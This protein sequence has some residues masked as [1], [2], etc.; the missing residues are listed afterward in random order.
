[1]ANSD[2]AAF[3]AAVEGRSQRLTTPCG[4]GDMVWHRWGSAPTVLVLLHGGF[5]SWTHW[6]R[7]VDALSARY[8]VIAADLPGLGDSASAPEPYDGGTL[9][10]IVADGI[11]R[12]VPEGTRCHLTGFSFGG[13]LGG[14]TAALL[15]DRLASF[16]IVGAGGMG[17]RRKPLE[18]V[19]WRHLPDEAARNAA[20]RANLS[21]LMIADP[22]RIDD[23]AVFLQAGNAAR[24]RT[25]SRPISL[26]STLADALPLVKAPVAAIFGE[27]DAT[28]Y[29]WVSER[30][31]RMRAMRP[32]LDFRVI[33]DAG[34]WVQ[35][36]A[37]ERFN[38]ELLDILSRRDRAA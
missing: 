15:G 16:T 1:M 25:K 30:E 6:I 5:G 14:P 33:P 37:A 35:Y 36:E 2:P 23:L 12:L 11:R 26:A 38:A 29:P 31:E 18:L 9:S 10:A 21:L 3:L 28:A 7:N 19:A 24:G 27:R 13:V 8:T 20:H 17:A 32:E 4:D 22:A 34:H